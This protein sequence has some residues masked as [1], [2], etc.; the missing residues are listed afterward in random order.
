M[1]III[2][3]LIYKGLCNKYRNFR[4]SRNF[5]HS[6]QTVSGNGQF[7]VVPTSVVDH[8]TPP[9]EIGV[10]FLL[11]SR[12][13]QRFV[14][15]KTLQKDIQAA[16]GLHVST[17]TIRTLQHQP[18]LHP[19]SGSFSITVSINLDWVWQDNIASELCKSV[20]PCFLQW[21]IQI[22]FRLHWWSSA[23]LETICEEVCWPCCCRT[24]QIRRAKSDGLN[25]YL[26][27]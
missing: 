3:I 17:Q 12:R 22:L 11:L 8:K 6:L 13:R 24:W 15:A 7:S 18:G 19:Q 4:V 26:D 2:I 20:A 14:V 5:I 23:G 9:W 1:V 21:R 10:F 25:R 16:T 27:W